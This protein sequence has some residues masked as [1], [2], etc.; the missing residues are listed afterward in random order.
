MPRSLLGSNHTL[1]T[2]EEEK[3]DPM[4][5]YKVLQ[6]SGFDYAS[7]LADGISMNIPAA[8]P[9]ERHEIH[10][11]LMGLIRRKLAPLMSYNDRVADDI[12]AGLVKD[13][14]FSSAGMPA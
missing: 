14:V 2:H 6:V 13:R 9:Q 3:G 11:E 12:V 1:S 4:I 8:M 10:S 5:P 7:H